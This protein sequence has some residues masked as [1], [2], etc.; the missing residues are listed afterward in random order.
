MYRNFDEIVAAAKKHKEKKTIAVAASHDHEILESAVNARKM[1]LAEFILIGDAVKTAE[2]LKELGEA[3]TDWNIIHEPDEQ[4]NAQMAVRLV[5]EGK[6]NIPMKGLM[7]TASFLRATFNKE[8]GLVEEKG[9]VSC[10]TVTEYPAENRLML[11]TDVAINVAPDYAAKIKLINGAVGLAERLGITM[12]KVAI[13][14][15][16]ETVNPNMPETVDAAMLCKAADRG[17]IKGCVV[18]GPL[19]LDNAVSQQAAD[20]KG[21]GGP[22]AGKADILI[23]PNLLAGNSL[24][25]SLRYFGRLKTGSFLAGG[26]VPL[27]ACSRSDSALNKMHAI[28]LSVL[29]KHD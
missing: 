29:E 10:I 13:V 20:I 8:Y 2:I 22:V 6:A 19:A 4:K 12:P 16:V 1:G 21:I 11:I 24:D 25:K 23:M 5:A 28:A 27:I 15:A 18:D 14:T 9:L 3:S 7:H 17:Q 26:K